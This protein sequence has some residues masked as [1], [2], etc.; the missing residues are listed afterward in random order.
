MGFRESELSDRIFLFDI[1]SEICG[2]CDLGW[3]F[4]ELNSGFKRKK[5]QT[6][7]GKTLSASDREIA[8]DE[9][10][11]RKGGKRGESSAFRVEWS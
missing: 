8:S 4:K 6:L 10:A 7:E 5:V 9:R 11:L 1:F 3:E 2:L